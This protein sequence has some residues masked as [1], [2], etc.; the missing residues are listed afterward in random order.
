MR[1]SQLQ[2]FLMNWD[3]SGL[4]LVT[5][6]PPV[7]IGD[8]GQ[9]AWI[10]MSNAPSDPVNKHP[11]MISEDMVPLAEETLVAKKDGVYFIALVNLGMMKR[12]N[13][14]L[15]KWIKEGPK[16]IGLPCTHCHAKTVET[17]NKHLAPLITDTTKGSRLYG[18][19]HN[20]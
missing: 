5:T 14:F 18:I 7:T 4:S 16:F 17:S 2:S 9:H 15:E 13:T 20:L 6:T 1:R 11:E 10:T 12:C 19:M 8:P 3:S